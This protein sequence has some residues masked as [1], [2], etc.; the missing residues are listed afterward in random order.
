MTIRK[1]ISVC[2]PLR[3]MTSLALNFDFA[4]S[5]RHEFPSVEQVSK[6]IKRAIVTS[7]GGT[8]CIFRPS[9]GSA[10][11]ALETGLSS[12]IGRD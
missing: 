11:H 5:T 10:V 8:V 4:H 3:P 6:P 12:A 2:S 1:I 7:T 9:E